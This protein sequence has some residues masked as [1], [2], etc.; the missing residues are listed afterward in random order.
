MEQVPWEGCPG[1]GRVARLWLAVGFGSAAEPKPPAHTVA[2][3]R[4]VS[5][6]DAHVQQRGFMGIVY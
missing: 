1:W 2:S 5:S 3:T 6:L 4:G